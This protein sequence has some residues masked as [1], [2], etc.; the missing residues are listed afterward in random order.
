MRKDRGVLNGLFARRF[1]LEN[2]YIAKGQLFVGVIAIDRQFITREQLYGKM[3]NPKELWLALLNQSFT[4]ELDRLDNLAL[5]F[6]NELME[7]QRENFEI[8]LYLQ[9]LFKEGLILTRTNKKDILEQF[10]RTSVWEIPN[11][12]ITSEHVDILSKFGLV[13]ALDNP[14]LDQECQKTMKVPTIWIELADTEFKHSNF[15]TDL[16]IREGRPYSK[17]CYTYLVEQ[18]DLLSLPVLIQ[19]I[20]KTTAI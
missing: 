1:D 12:R 11:Q 16:I 7:E 2:S 14:N 10:A 13:H 3:I 18:V 8:R 17:S 19:R 15:Q 9:D 4:D 5:K 6:W 20:A